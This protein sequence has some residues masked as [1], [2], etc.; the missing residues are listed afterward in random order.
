M[1]KPAEIRQYIWETTAEMMAQNILL[2]NPGQK[3]IVPMI[4][5][6]WPETI[7][8]MLRNSSAEYDY[9]KDDFLAMSFDRQHYLAGPRYS[10]E[11]FRTEIERRYTIAKCLLAAGRSQHATA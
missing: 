1:K 10:F 7:H 3:V 4:R 8:S 6:I 2:E 9:S 11:Q 5:T